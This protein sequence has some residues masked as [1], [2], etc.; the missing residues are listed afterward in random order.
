MPNSMFDW[1]EATQTSPMSTSWK[2]SVF[3]PATVKVWGA[4]FCGTGGRST[5]QAPSAPAMAEP[6]AP[7]SVTVTFSAGSAHPQ[8]GIF[9]S[10]CSTM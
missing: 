3:F 6:L 5:R 7:P 4:V 2:V 1:P 8:T 10:S 9:V